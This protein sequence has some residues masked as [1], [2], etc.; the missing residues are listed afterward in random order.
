MTSAIKYR[1]MPLNV[2]DRVVAARGGREVVGSVVYVST[3]R[4]VCCVR[5]GLDGF[6]HVLTGRVHPLE[7]G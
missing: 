1:Q 3:D 2:G 5:Y 7:V 4:R 6:L